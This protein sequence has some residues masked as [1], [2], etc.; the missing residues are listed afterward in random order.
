MYADFLP[1]FQHEF[2]F[3]SS[4]IFHP[5]N[6]KHIPTHISIHPTCYILQTPPKTTQ[7]SSFSFLFLLLKTAPFSNTNFHF[8]QL[9]F[10]LL[11]IKLISIQTYIHSY[12][13]TILHLYYTNSSKSLHFP[14]F[15]PLPFCHT[16]FFSLLSIAFFFSYTL[17]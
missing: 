11:I 12:I 14:L 9:I 13:Y 8:F 3:F 4:L 5:L 10:H 7:I 1:T 16:N 15:F 17:V 6:H 2:Y